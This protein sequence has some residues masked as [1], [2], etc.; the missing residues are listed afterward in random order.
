MNILA[1][2]YKEMLEQWR[3]HR[4]L[5]VAAV[6]VIFGLI[7]PLTAKFMP[8]IFKMLPGAEW[9]AAAMPQ[10]T[11]KDAVDQY[12][13]NISQFSLIIGILMTM[14]AVAQEKERGTAALML[15]KPLSRWTFLLSKFV[16][17]L[18]VFAVS[19]LLAGLGA[20]YYTLFLFGPVPVLP[21][22]ALNGLLLV[23]ALVYVALTLFFSS[24]GRSQAL[25]GGLALAA[26]AV[27]GVLG[28]IPTLGGFVPGQ[29]V[30]WGASLM[31]QTGQAAWPAL[32]ASL[33]II[34]AALLG[35]W[36]VLRRQEI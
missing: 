27:L 29:L 2:F 25:A 31:Q 17:F 33:G 11:A 5:V 12:V 4:F 34:L 26:M 7:S 9:F 15:V 21:W 10:P 20:Y 35:G 22:L 8:E 18:V 32:W 23:Y 16:A 24:L 6:L 14:G 36:L 3:T 28:S 1:A 19:I 13:K 30:S